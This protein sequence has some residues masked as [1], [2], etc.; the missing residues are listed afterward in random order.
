[1]GY[2]IISYAPYFEV[3]EG[4]VVPYK[5]SRHH[6]VYTI[7]YTYYVQNFKNLLRVKLITRQKDKERQG[8]YNIQ[9]QRD[10]QRKTK[11][12]RQKNRDRNAEREKKY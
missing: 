12:D 8:E 3:Q 7:Q 6:A 1:M 10:R 4:V 9:N 11:T 5:I 2:L